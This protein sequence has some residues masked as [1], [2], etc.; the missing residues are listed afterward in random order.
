[1]RR[2][3][4]ISDTRVEI[5]ILGALEPGEVI[6]VPQRL[7]ELVFPANYFEV[8][9]D[10]SGREPGQPPEPD[11]PQ[12]QPQQ[13]QPQQQPAPGEQEPQFQPTAPEQ[14]QPAPEPGESEGS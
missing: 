2:I 11:R 14:P 6:V 10:E 13:P 3:K 12:E 9:D 7:S 8:E 5:P 4:N 1:M